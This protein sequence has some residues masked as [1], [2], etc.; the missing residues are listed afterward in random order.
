MKRTLIVLGAAVL[1]AALLLPGLVG[2]L[3]LRQ[4][5]RQIGMTTRASPH[6]RLTTDS[7]ERGWF[8]SHGR[9]TVELSDELQRVIRR[10]APEGEPATELP[11]LRVDSALHHGPFALTAAFTHGGTLKPVLGTV[12]STLTLVEDGE[13]VFALP[14]EVVTHL[15]FGGGGTAHYASGPIRVEDPGESLSWGGADVEIDFSAGASRIS[16]SGSLAALTAVD[17]DGRLVAGP[18]EFSFEQSMSGFGFRL[19]E[20]RLEMARLA[21]TARGRAQAGLQSVR[22]RWAARLPG[23]SV[24]AEMEL[25]IAEVG[26]N[27]WSG[28]PLVFRMLLREL[29]PEA[30]GRFL[31][32][33][34]T[35]N[36]AAATGTSSQPAGISN[37]LAA[38]LANGA[39]FVLEEL[40][41][42][43]PE[44]ELYASATVEFP[45]KPG[46]G[47]DDLLLLAFG[48][49]WDVTVRV[50]IALAAAAA[51]ANPD[52]QQ[53]VQLLRDTGF[54]RAEDDHYVVHAV[55]AGGLL[56]V[57][58]I[59]VPMPFS[60]TTT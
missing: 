32:A 23:E 37:E 17:A 56:T 50:P 52:S 22:M 26:A 12:V 19:G 24:V 31:K 18:L 47:G 34:Q 55:Y 40:R 38:L 4:H 60:A 36:P 14:G 42:R 28:G 29:E 10:T 35:M 49:S 16:G 33:L 39:Q 48:S 53:Y 43:T 46:A 7:F 11:A 1:A 58:G 59:P 25:A 20:S 27:G 21:Y 3:A 41:M 54:L 13:T 8:R 30:L 44:G 15:R 9:Y 5:E 51:A 6:I 45:D 57:N 2:G